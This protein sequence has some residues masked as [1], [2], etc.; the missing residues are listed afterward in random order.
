MNS[1]LFDSL[2]DTSTLIMVAHV[3]ECVCNEIRINDAL[4]TTVHIKRQQ[5]VYEMFYLKF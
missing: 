4:M 5:N 2:M 3:C 1:K